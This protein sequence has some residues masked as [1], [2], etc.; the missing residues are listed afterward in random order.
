MNL[1]ADIGGYPEA[2]EADLQTGNLDGR[3]LTEVRLERGRT[4]S[5]LRLIKT[6]HQQTKNQQQQ[7]LVF[8]LCS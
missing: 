7:L 3:V 6:D 1:V 5:Y 4:L 2:S 8:C